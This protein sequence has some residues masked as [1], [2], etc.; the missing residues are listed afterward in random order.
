MLFTSTSWRP[1][2]ISVGRRIAYEQSPPCS[3]HS[4]AALP[5]KYGNGESAL[6]WLTLRWTI[7]RTCAWEAAWKRLLLRSTASA[8]VM[9][10][11]SKRTQ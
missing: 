9:P 5:R 3:A 4:T 8:K 11:C 10:P 1:P 2:K 6:A 7:R